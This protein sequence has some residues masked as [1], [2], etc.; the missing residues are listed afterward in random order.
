MS[1]QIIEYPRLQ[2]K[3]FSK[4][5]QK[6]RA[7]CIFRRIHGDCYKPV[8]DAAYMWRNLL[9]Y[10]LYLDEVQTERSKLF[11]DVEILEEK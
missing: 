3:D 1:A 5:P 4:I 8:N 11:I 10:G 6:L 7:H 9:T 2:L